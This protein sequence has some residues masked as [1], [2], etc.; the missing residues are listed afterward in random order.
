MRLSIQS[1]CLERKIW[2]V[3]FEIAHVELTDCTPYMY[4]HATVVTLE[5]N[6]DN[7]FTCEL[8][9]ALLRCLRSCKR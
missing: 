4:V 7:E 3:G 2:D 8:V 5:Y 6:P 9:C 1:V